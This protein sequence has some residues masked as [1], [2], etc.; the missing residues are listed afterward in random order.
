MPGPT[1]VHPADLPKAAS[2]GRRLQTAP[3]S[4]GSLRQG[5]GAPEDSADPKLKGACEEMEALFLHHLLSEMRKTIEK[6]GLV[7]GGRAE[8]IYTS[9][10]DAELAQQMARDGGL[11]LSSLLLEQMRDRSGFKTYESTSKVSAGPRR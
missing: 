5:F 7:D 8:E 9:L 11:G 3:A 10:M 6:S 4:P 1:A 2:Q